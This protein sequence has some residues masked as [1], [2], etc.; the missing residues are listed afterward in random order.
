MRNEKI[1]V[2]DDDPAI[3]R[4]VWKSLQSTG[5]LIYQAETIEKTLELIKKIKFDLFLLDV[6]LVN[7]NDGFHL[8]RLIR[9]EEVITPII[10]I[11]GRKKE[12]DVITGLETGADYYMTKP[13]SPSILR[14]QVL[15]TLDRNQMITKSL[16][17]DEDE[18]IVNGPFIFDKKL[19]VLKKDQVEIDLSAKEVLLM[20]F[21][22]ENPNQVFSKKQIYDN[23]WSQD[24]QVEEE[25]ELNLVMVY[26]NYLR[27]K[28]E[29]NPKKPIYLKTV[30][31]IGYSFEPES[32]KEN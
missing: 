10:F 21:F 20:K 26:M 19:Y 9:D 12:Q 17:Y 29:E 24:K 16:E 32:K 5:I 28:I 13:F 23:I 15:N 31:G 25:S 3:R 4:S 7:D 1:L 11:S 8:A 22:M 30:W 14:A 2:V 6:M 18:D 27:N